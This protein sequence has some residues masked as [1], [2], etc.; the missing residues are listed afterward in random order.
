VQVAKEHILN[1]NDL[2]E[3][4]AETRKER[5]AMLLKEDT[6]IYKPAHYS[7][8]HDPGVQHQLTDAFERNVQVHSVI[9][10]SQGSP[11][12]NFLT[13]KPLKVRRQNSLS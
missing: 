11:I 6:F 7:V 10:P 9:L 8:R 13:K 3:I 12:S 1:L 5:V 2:N 4:N